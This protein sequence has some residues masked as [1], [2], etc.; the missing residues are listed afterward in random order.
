MQIL[1]WLQIQMSFLQTEWFSVVY[2]LVVFLNPFAMVPQLISSVR[3]KPEELR[4]VS[5]TML[6]LFLVIQIAVALGAI[7][8]VDMA[9]FASMSIS[10]VVTFTVIVI[11]IF[12]RNLKM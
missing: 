7:K 12:R 11:T 9:L 1:Q 10:T 6:I 3:A 4:G 2:G 5:V 8:N